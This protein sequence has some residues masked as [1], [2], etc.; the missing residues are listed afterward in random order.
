MDWGRRS[1]RRRRWLLRGGE[2][3]ESRKIKKEMMESMQAEL[4]PERQHN[5]EGSSEHLSLIWAHLCKQSI[6]VCVKWTCSRK[7]KLISLQLLPSLSSQMRDDS[8][9]YE[10]NDVFF[11]CGAYL[12]KLHRYIASQTLRGIMSQPTFQS[13]EAERLN[14]RRKTE[15]P[16]T[17]LCLTGVLDYMDQIVFAILIFC[18]TFEQ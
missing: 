6:L 10:L 7:Y 15:A 18:F 13:S 16:M 3:K 12:W 11:L 17:L 8:S 14:L 1:C 4:E 5:K 9:I 2:E